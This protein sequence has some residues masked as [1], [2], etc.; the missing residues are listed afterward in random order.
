LSFQEI[1]SCNAHKHGRDEPCSVFEV[2]PNDESVLDEDYET[3]RDG[4]GTGDQEESFVEVVEFCGGEVLE[5]R[6][7]S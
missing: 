6:I 4:T 3:K 7:H 1:P 5:S 2:V